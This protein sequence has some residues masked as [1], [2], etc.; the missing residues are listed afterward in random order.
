MFYPFHPLCGSTLAVVSR[1]KETVTVVA[2]DER[3]LKI[4]VWM[5]RSDAAGYSIADEPTVDLRA[6]FG[7]SP[8]MH[9][10]Q[11]ERHATLSESQTTATAG[12]EDETVGAG[13]LHEAIER[14]EATAGRLDERAAHSLNGGD[15]SRSR[16]LE[17]EGRR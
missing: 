12:G 5:T 2:G 15:D 13:A 9:P 6:L 4:P 8:L 10:K 1:G 7:L 17:Q 11:T 14:Q 16:S 3:R